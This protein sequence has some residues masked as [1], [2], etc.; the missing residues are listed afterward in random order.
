M[1]HFDD[2]PKRDR[3]SVIEEKALAAF[4]NLISRSKDFICQGTDRKD[5]GMDCQIEVVAN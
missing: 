1:S 3:N 4:Q 2:L 5:Y